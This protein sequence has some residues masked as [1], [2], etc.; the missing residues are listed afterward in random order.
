MADLATYRSHRSVRTAVVADA[1]RRAVADLGPA[2]LTIVDLGGG[3]G[4][5]AVRVAELGH[6]VT[7]VDRSPDALASLHRRAV[8]SC[9]ADRVLAVQ[10]DA[11]D[12]LDHVPPAGADVVLCHGVLEI[13]DDPGEALTA[14]HHVLRPDSG[15]LSVVVSGRFAGVLTRA[16]SGHLAQAQAL[17]AAGIGDWDLRIHGPRRYTRDEIVDLVRRHGHLVHAVHAV[18]VFTDLVPG[19]MVDSEPGA[20]QALLE[21]ERAVAEIPEFAAVAGQLHVLAVRD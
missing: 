18:R 15:R 14:I 21:L 8:E 7:V 3:T 16:L 19:A 20:Q 13:V 2:P 4:G 17:L 10:G 11:A 6:Q 12:L 9:V 1:V 5:F